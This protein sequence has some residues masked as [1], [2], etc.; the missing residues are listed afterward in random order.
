MIWYWKSRKIKIPVM[1]KCTAHFESCSCESCCVFG[2]ANV[3]VNHRLNPTPNDR[4]H[5]DDKLVKSHNGQR[6]NDTIIGVKKKRKTIP[7]LITLVLFLIRSRVSIGVSR[8]SSRYRVDRENFL[9]NR[10][11][12]LA[13]ENR[14]IIRTAHFNEQS[15][16]KQQ[17]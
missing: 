13:C 4:N 6:K 14:V 3:R 15:L 11:R 10:C 12:I 9:V 16:S 7:L 5:I 17:Y 1:L 8:C 2:F